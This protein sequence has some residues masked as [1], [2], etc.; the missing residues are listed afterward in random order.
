MIL[1]KEDKFSDDQAV[2]VTVASTN[3][4]DFGT[5]ES[6]D[7]TVKELVVQVTE[8]FT[9]AGAATLGVKVQTSVDEVFSSPIDVV[10]LGTI[11]K[12][13]LIAGYRFPIRALPHGMKRWGRL[14]YTVTT[15]PMTAGKIN[16]GIALDAQTNG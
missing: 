3:V 10:D 12:E 16:A 5:A 6:G 15:G 7:G 4:I 8:D 11:A 1:S 2:T 14:Y 9:A 13:T